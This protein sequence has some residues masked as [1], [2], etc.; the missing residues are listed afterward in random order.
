MSAIE[1]VIVDAIT[2][3]QLRAARALVNWSQEQ[4]A[5]ASEIPK[6]TI[7]RMELGQGAPQRR[8]VSALRAALESA[9]VVFVPGNGDGPGVRLRK[10]RG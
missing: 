5:Q 8:T 2:A 9:G 6:R 7:A 1:N 4:L 10:D 3:A